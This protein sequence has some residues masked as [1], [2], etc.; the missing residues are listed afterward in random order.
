MFLKLLDESY[1]KI[2]TPV[3]RDEFVS[4]YTLM[5]VKFVQFWSG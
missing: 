5:Q 3:A 1:E 4:K 2:E